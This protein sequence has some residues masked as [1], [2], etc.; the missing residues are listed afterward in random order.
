M[1]SN[2][3]LL[4]TMLLVVVPFQAGAGTNSEFV[5]VGNSGDTSISVFKVNANGTLKPLEPRVISPICGMPTY[6]ATAGKALLA[7]GNYTD[8]C[9]QSAELGGALI[10]L[11]PI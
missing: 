6:L 5:Y 7:A 4:F 3:L 8:V 11:Y 2:V 10:Y 1:R 9:N